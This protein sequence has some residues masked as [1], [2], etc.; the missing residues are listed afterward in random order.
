M[1]GKSLQKIALPATLVMA[2]GNN[3]FNSLNI[4]ENY[5]WNMNEGG[6]VQLLKDW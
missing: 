6:R 5:F 4:L 3:T 2:K 1:L